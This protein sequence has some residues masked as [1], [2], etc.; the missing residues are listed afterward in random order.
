MILGSKN[1]AFWIVPYFWE[2][3]ECKKCAEKSYFILPYGCQYFDFFVGVYS[4]LYLA[5]NRSSTGCD[6]TAVVLHFILEAI[7][8]FYN[9]YV[10]FFV[11]TVLASA[12]DIYLTEYCKSLFYF[13][14]QYLCPELL[15]SLPHFILPLVFTC[16]N[17]WPQSSLSVFVLCI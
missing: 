8:F 9:S 10:T 13:L 1:Q 12:T 5:L 4:I 3:L 17:I 6:G 14:V 16:I 2:S 15:N 7:L 11:A